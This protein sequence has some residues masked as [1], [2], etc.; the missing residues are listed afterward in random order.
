MIWTDIP[1]GEISAYETQAQI[2]LTLLRFLGTSEAR[3]TFLTSIPDADV[4]ARFEADW[5]TFC[6]D[7]A[8]RLARIAATT[9]P[10]QE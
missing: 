3:T 8:A 7:E 9:P 10:P 1:A 2:R 4:R 6:A 5:A